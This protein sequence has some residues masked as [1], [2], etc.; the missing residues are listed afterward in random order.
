[1]RR[2][3][4]DEAARL[5][6]E[7][8]ELAR[9]VGLPR[10]IGVSLWAHG[11]MTGGETGIEVLS[12]AVR[13][14]ERSP[15]RIEHGRALIDLGA[16]LRRAG[17]RREARAALR[18]G[19]ELARACGAEASVERAQLELRA[20]GGRPRAPLRTGA[21]ALTAS[22]LR[23]CKLAAAGASNPEIA[24]QLYVTRA[25]VESHLRSAYGKLGIASRQQ[26]AAALS[27]AQP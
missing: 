18:D 13:E 26:L 25:T 15:A 17:R 6:L 1:L 4:R 11:L 21:D 7:E 8:L 3:E 24:Q 20:A 12:E 23:V 10:P 2:G 14:L 19:V 5:V 16:A 22:E 27:T 9:R